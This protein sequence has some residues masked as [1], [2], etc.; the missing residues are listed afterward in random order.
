MGPGL[1]EKERMSQIPVSISRLPD[2]DAICGQ[3]PHSS[4]QAFPTM[5]DWNFEPEQ[6]FLPVTI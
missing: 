3:L 5:I 6:I 4:H 2:S 1:R